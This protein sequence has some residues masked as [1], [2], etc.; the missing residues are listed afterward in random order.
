MARQISRKLK[1]IL[2]T[3]NTGNAKYINSAGEYPEQYPKNMGS[4]PR[5]TDT[6]SG[7]HD[8]EIGMW[9]YDIPERK[10]W[11]IKWDWNQKPQK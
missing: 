8:Y 7:Q 2:G 1:A 6:M 9:I 11:F 10:Q 5:A 3:S 4:P